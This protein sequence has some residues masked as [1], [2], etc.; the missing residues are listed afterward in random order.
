MTDVVESES[1]M[2][3]L[4]DSLLEGKVV[5]VSGG[6]QGLGRRSRPLRHATA[7]PWWS[8]AI[9]PAASLRAR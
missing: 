2:T 9:T 5:L 7:P 8:P 1:L 6:I 3:Q 4:D